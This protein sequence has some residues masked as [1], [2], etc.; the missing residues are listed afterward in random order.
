MDRHW[1]RDGCS[2][3]RDLGCRRAGGADGRPRRR[4]RT[5]R[6]VSWGDD[7]QP[8]TAVYDV[9]AFGPW[10]LPGL[11]RQLLPTR[12]RR[13]STT[14]PSRPTT[15]IATASPGHYA[16]APQTDE[17]HSDGRSTTRLPPDRPTSRARPRL[18]GRA[19]SVPIQGT[20]SDSANPA[21]RA[22]H[23]SDGQT[24]T[25]RG[26]GQL[27]SA[28]RRDV[29]DQRQLWPMPD[30]PG[31]ADATSVTVDNTPPRPLTRLPPATVAGRPPSSGWSAHGVPYTYRI[32]EHDR[33]RPPRFPDVIS[34]WKMTPI[35]LPPATYIYTVEGESTRP[36]TSTTSAPAIP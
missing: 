4:P 16:D 24:I 26:L 5:R 13:L 8:T 7:T 32:H 31:A 14:R 23:P 3:D 15:P 21:Q 36:A 11:T 6:R 33:A 17:Q 20:G 29:R 12:R 10:Q 34:R 18:H 9:H 28:R 25:P 22:S 30:N 19:A 27:L 2:G 1:R 35:T